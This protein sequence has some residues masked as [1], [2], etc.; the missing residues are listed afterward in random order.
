M[1][2]KKLFVFGIVLIVSLINNVMA[3]P[4]FDD[5]LFVQGLSRTRRSPQNPLS[6]WC[7][8]PFLNFA[9]FKPRFC[10]PNPL[11]KLTLSRG[12]RDCS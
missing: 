12:S 9:R 8:S 4:S 10:P 1:D 2:L 7:N 11:C 3:R 5:Q 6:P